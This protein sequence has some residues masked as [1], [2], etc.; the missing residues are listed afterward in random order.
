MSYIYRHVLIER[1]IDGDTVALEI[2]L[3]NK[4]KWR[5][6]FRLMG[7]D[8]PERGQPGYLEATEHLRRLLL[9]PLSRIETHKPDKFGRWLVDLYLDTD[10]G[11]LHVNRLMIVDGHSREYFGG[12][13]T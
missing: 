9:L 2:D 10:G 11:D 5:D 3:G 13:K 8:T 4:I 1:I 12:A 6:T 7:I